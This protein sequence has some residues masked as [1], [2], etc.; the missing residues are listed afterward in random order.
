MSP[1]GH[2]QVHEHPSRPPE[3]SP[4]RCRADPAAGLMRWG[5]IPPA[6]PRNQRGP[7]ARPDPEA[8]QVR[9]HLRVRPD[10]RARPG[11]PGSEGQPGAQDP[12][13][14]QELPGVSGRR[15]VQ[16]G[17]G[18]PGPTYVLGE[19]GR[20]P[21]PPIR[22]HRGGLRCVGEPTV[23]GRAQGSFLAAAA[24][25]SSS[26]DRERTAT[27]AG[28]VGHP[29]RRGQLVEHGDGLIDLAGSVG[30]R[31]RGPPGSPGG[32]GRRVVLGRCDPSVTPILSSGPGPCVGP[33]RP[34]RCTLER[35]PHARSPRT[36]ELSRRAQTLR[37]RTRHTSEP[38][39]RSVQPDGRWR[40]SWRVLTGPVEGRRW[41]RTADLT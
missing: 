8:S 10:L 35:R 39:S 38:S 11:S 36:D 29:P 22:P 12:E 33:P 14:N 26:V 20:R 7:G 25:T 17:R 40:R 21:R 1:P 24:D 3:L 19:H 41:P 23:C 27:P 32:P 28:P 5:G 9:P 31:E 37:A 15:G 2:G 34:S 18:P 13:A 30:A 6:P 16:A 4:Q